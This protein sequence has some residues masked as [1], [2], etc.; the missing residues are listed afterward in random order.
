MA[1]AKIIALC[2]ML[3]TLGFWA[4]TPALVE[5]HAPP[6]A[7]DTG[8]ISLTK[9]PLA[10]P[11]QGLSAQVGKFTVD[12]LIQYALLLQPS[13]GIPVSGWPVIIFNH[14]FHPEPHNNGRRTLDGVSDRP[15]DYYRQIPQALARQGFLV[16]VPDY[17]GHNDS[18]GAEF[19]L[20]E[21]SPRWYVRDVLGLIEALKHDARANMDH[22]FMLGHSMGAEVTLYA[23]AALGDQLKG[24]SIWSASVPTVAKMSPQYDEVEAASP[25]KPVYSRI[26]SPIN[27]HHAKDD[28][29]TAFEGSLMV[30]SQLKQLGKTHELY[31]YLSA[32]HLFTGENLQLAITRD[33]SFFR[34][35]MLAQDGFLE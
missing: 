34:R 17:R 3:L 16:V 24:A 28:A 12:G 32:N 6:P 22:F 20:Q 31:S 30:A 5:P 29:T 26:Y 23:A 13:D 33:I 8:F 11:L 1:V 25:F 14:G 21:S 10:K 2:F 19:T 9:N 35:I 18:S 7:I 15:G 27:I 4:H